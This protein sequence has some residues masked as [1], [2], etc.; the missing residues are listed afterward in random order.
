MH[1]TSMGCM[2]VPTAPREV[3]FATDAP[4]SHMC[5]FMRCSV[6]QHADRPSTAECAHQSLASH[7]L[8]CLLI[9]HPD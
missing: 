6:G 8:C 2:E 3:Y 9:D 7:K 1:R 4:R 5:I